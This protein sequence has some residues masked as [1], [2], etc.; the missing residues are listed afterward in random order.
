MPT[1]SVN[2]LSVQGLHFVI[3]RGKLF[4][5][6]VREYW[7]RVLVSLGFRQSESRISA[8]SQRYW[9]RTDG[10]RWAADSHLRDAPV[11]DGSD[12]W[13]RIG[14]EHLDL[15][16]R[17]ARMVGFTR[18]WHRVV[19]WGC[20]GGANAVH[21]APRA[22]EFI[23]IDISKE[24]LDECAKQVA[25]LCDTPF[26]S[27]HIDVAHPERVT[28]SN[29]GQCDIFL[30]FYVFEL[31]PTPEYG[32]RILRIAHELLTPGSLALIQIKYDDGRLLTRPRRRSYVTALADMTTYSIPSFWQLAEKCGFVP[33]MVY[34]VPKNELDERYA[35]YFLT[36][37]G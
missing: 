21:F 5:V 4:A 15:F 14:H 29:V 30:C 22:R 12:L 2:R 6:R 25:S 11:F 1:N 23:G 7:L 31:I 35:Y 9:T 16:E 18:P 28:R 20:G 24:T 3:D 13:S 10:K 32:E 8:D 17:G 37:E 33:E 26:R 36:R 19:E 34:L 27:V